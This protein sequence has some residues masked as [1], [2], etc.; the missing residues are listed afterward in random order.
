MDGWNYFPLPTILRLKLT[1]WTLPCSHWILLFLI[2]INYI[3]DHPSLISAF[4]W[5]QNVRLKNLPWCLIFSPL[6]NSECED[7]KKDNFYMKRWKCS[8]QHI[9]ATTWPGEREAPLQALKKC[10]QSPSRSPSAG[11]AIHLHRVRDGDTGRYWDSC[12]FN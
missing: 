2:M 6:S 4:V 12:H 11:M 10:C 9:A 3:S 5:A 8:G 7:H 1:G